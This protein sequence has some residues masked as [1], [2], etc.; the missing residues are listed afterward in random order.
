LRNKIEL[1][2]ANLWPSG[3]HKWEILIRK[4][5][6]IKELPPITEG[7]VFGLHEMVSKTPMSCKIS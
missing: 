7:Q 6:I 2:N 5:K 1:R 3:T 4:R